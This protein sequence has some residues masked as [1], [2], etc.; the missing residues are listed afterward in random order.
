MKRKVHP[1]FPGASE[2]SLLLKKTIIQKNVFS[3]TTAHSLVGDC[4]RVYDI[5]YNSK[6]MADFYPQIF[7]GNANKIL[8]TTIPEFYLE[9]PLES[10]S[11]FFN[12][13]E[14]TSN[15][16]NKKMNLKIHLQEI[17]K[18]YHEYPNCSI[19]R[20]ESRFVL[21]GHN[22]PI[23]DL[24][25]SKNMRMLF[26]AGFDGCILQWD[27]DLKSVVYSFEESKE[28]NIKEDIEN[29]VYSIQFSADDKFLFAAKN[30]TVLIWEIHSKKLIGKLEGGHDGQIFSIALIPNTNKIF[31]GG[32]D[33]KI[34]LWNYETCEKLRIFEEHQDSIRKLKITPDSEKMISGSDDGTLIFW[35]IH[36]LSTLPFQE[37]ISHKKKGV[38]SLEISPD[39]KKVFS[40]GV[41]HL[42]MMWDISSGG[43]LGCFDNQ[44]TP[45]VLTIN[46]KGDILISGGWDKIIRFWDIATK[47]LIQVLEGHTDTVRALILLGNE[48][49]ISASSDKSIR[50]WDFSQD[51]EKKFLQNHSG[52]I[53]AL[54]L[55]SD[56]KFLVSVSDDRTM[57]LWDLSQ[58]TLKHIFNTQEGHSE[59]VKFIC[60]TSNRICSSSNDQKINI[61]SI[62]ELKREFCLEGHTDHINCMVISKDEKKLISGGGDKMIIIW[63][64]ESRK[65]IHILQG[66]ESFVRSLALSFDGNRLIS[67]SWDKTIRIWDLKSLKQLDILQENGGPVVAVAL[68]RNNK[69]LASA[70]L[71]R[72]IRVWDIEQKEIKFVLQG[73]NGSIKALLIS[74]DSKQIFSGS[75]D[76]TIRIWDIENKRQIVLLKGHFSAVYSLALLSDS[77][78]LISCS[79]DQTIRFWPL[80]KKVALEKLKGPTDAVRSIVLSPDGSYIYTGG[81]DTSIRIWNI[82]TC[83]QVGVI[84][85]HNGTV[86][87]LLATKDSERIVS[88]SGDQTIRVWV[89]EMKRQVKIFKDGHKGAIRVIVFVSY[90]KKIISG[91]EDGLILV[92]V[93]ESQKVIGKPME[94]GG[95]IHTLAVTSDERKIISAGNFPSINIWDIDARR[96]LH[97]IK[98]HADYVYAINLTPDDSKII[99]G[100]S[101]KNIKFY[102][103]EN[104]Q[105]LS[106]LD[107]E[108]E[109]RSLALSHDG[110]KLITGGEDNIIRI[111]DLNTGKLIKKLVGHTGKVKA[112]VISS[113]SEIISGSYDNTIKVWDSISG[114]QIREMQSTGTFYSLLLNPDATKIVAGRFEKGIRVWDIKTKNEPLKFETKHRDVIRSIIFTP[115]S[116]K[117]ISCSADTTIKVWD[118]HTSQLLMDLIG[119]TDTVFCLLVI[120]S[121]IQRANK[122][123]NLMNEEFQTDLKKEN[124]TGSV[125][126]SGSYDQ[127]IKIWDLCTGNL[128]RTFEAHKGAVFSLCE[129]PAEP[130]FLSAGQDGNI[131]YWDMRESKLIHTFISH[132]EP[133]RIVTISPK[134]DFFASG[135]I[136]K[137]IKLWDLNKKEEIAN[138]K[139][140]YSGTLRSLTVSPDCSKLVAGSFDGSFCVLDIASKT[141]IFQGDS[142]IAAQLQPFFSLKET[143]DR[144]IG[145]LGHTV[146]DFSNETPL[147]TLGE[148]ESLNEV[149]F[150]EIRKSFICV[151]KNDE[152]FIRSF[153]DIA[154][155]G[156]NFSNIKALF[157]ENEEENLNSLLKKF[158][159]LLPFY[160][161]FLHIIALFENKKPFHFKKFDSINIPL[162]YFLQRDF[163]GKTCLDI[164]IEFRLKSLLNT[165][166]ELAIN[167]LG[168][169]DTTFYQKMKFFSYE[170]KLQRKL[171]PI[172]IKNKDEIASRSNIYSFLNKLLE[173]FG[174]DTKIISNFFEN[175]Y[176]DIDAACFPDNYSIEELSQ[177]FFTVIHQISDLNKSSSLDRLLKP[178]QTGGLLYYIMIHN[179]IA[180][181]ISKLFKYFA[182][183][184]WKITNVQCKICLLNGV[185]DITEDSLR[186]HKQIMTFEPNNPIFSN[187]IFQM[188]INYKWQTY[189]R[190]ILL[191][192]FAA[193]LTVFL[194]YLANFIYIQ[195]VRLEVLD[196]EFN[197]Y[198]IASLV[199][200]IIIMVYFLFYAVYETIQLRRTKIS[201]YF[202]SPWN[203][204]DLMLVPL[205]NTGCILDIYSIYSESY[206][207]NAEKIVYSISILFFWIRILSFSRAFEGTGFMIRLIIQVILDMR[208]FLLMIILFNLAFSSAGFLIQKTFD[209][210]Q[211]QIFTLFYRLM[212]GDFGLYDEELTNVENNI[213]LWILMILF[214]LLLSVIMLN[215]L[216]SIIGE[217]FSKVRNAESSMK[218]YEL[219]SI[220]TEIEDSLSQNIKNKLRREGKIGNYLV[221]LY[222]QTS[223]FDKN[224][225]TFEKK[226]MD[227]LKNVNKDIAYLNK[228]ISDVSKE[229]KDIKK[230]FL[231]E[232]KD[233][234]E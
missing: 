56:E 144:I 210:G 96:C 60:C 91:G 143:N 193:M 133:V 149:L 86:F 128:I 207:I 59:A 141:V 187:K 113:P 119:H 19:D 146:Y 142:D 164:T 2:S 194:L 98:H 116:N 173:I 40:G 108:S 162:L 213:F 125:L 10:S 196:P 93:Y 82:K 179:L 118:S 226:V 106:T 3:K 163:M 188:L 53:R 7:P 197:H 172:K 159:I 165:F 57:K 111:W 21:L 26:S 90:E 100:D 190:K 205:V 227:E 127:T 122:N 24:Y 78:A 140:E 16:D 32:F 65:K 222:N 171:Q 215:L 195:P 192:K 228:S 97:S 169:N 112:L 109:I 29:V 178:S 18:K 203:W 46:K 189:G 218:F 28:K 180:N 15:E 38:R 136:D 217:T 148:Y 145:L 158:P 71:D 12:Q 83:K 209:V 44:S 175:S 134:K 27:F 147:F 34:V 55:S 33:K 107:G 139:V 208:Y 170:C 31:S 138:L 48:G 79:F 72:I 103:I 75:V 183:K 1:D 185:T 45:Y 17:L 154:D 120:S 225:E 184:T 129:I 182:T 8:K 4:R 37:P 231:S 126:I 114:S 61:W 230:L 64:F 216:I 131:Y 25:L 43:N 89:I 54:S 105:E 9:N 233:I 137:S 23:N 6:N 74:P 206:K 214:T 99:I 35:D 155:F 204:C 221:C 66:H 42:I 5:N 202:S 101:N 174:K 156:T 73:H 132:K 36:T 49:F 117:I 152:L 219:Y 95:S 229:L 68:S 67:G 166:M 167:S 123:I 63:E 87:S 124:Y 102:S 94:N 186:F 58:R 11:Y 110:R 22:E 70:S 85:G 50:I 39:S 220:I 30:E 201:N 212:L 151:N 199:L 80:K 177:P 135:S 181:L 88:A 20:D 150:S 176:F 104:L 77:S 161:N 211:W 121:V 168:S 62:T 81:A 14:N 157:E 41:D 130:K 92:W 13:S 232:M 76:K 200:D 191:I 224:E 69:I 52:P 153:Q 223:E 160:F 234:Q 115:D 47:N 84:W 198:K 51:S